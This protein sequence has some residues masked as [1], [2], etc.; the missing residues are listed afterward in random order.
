M[1]GAIAAPSF[2]IL[3][4][5]QREGERGDYLSRDLSFS[6]PERSNFLILPLPARSIADG[7]P[8]YSVGNQAD[9]QDRM[10]ERTACSS[11]LVGQDCTM[12][13]FHRKPDADRGPEAEPSEPGSVLSA[14]AWIP[15]SPWGYGV[16][17]GCLTAEGT[18]LAYRA[19]RSAA[20]V[21][22]KPHNPIRCVG[23]PK[24]ADA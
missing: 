1:E 7:L 22:G 21:E 2:F 24:A 4:L 5:F 11:K 3:P 20:A 19:A 17:A 10:P 13:Y 12:G 23:A 18:R 16:E 15:S 8:S 9:A 14:K 6:L